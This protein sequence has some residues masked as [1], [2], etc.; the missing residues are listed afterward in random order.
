MPGRPMTE[1]HVQSFYSAC[2]ISSFSMC[3]D[4]DKKILSLCYKHVI[5]RKFTFGI[6]LL[7]LQG[8]LTGHRNCCL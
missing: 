5:H 3:L 7:N 8:D 2:L 6:M 4:S 1:E